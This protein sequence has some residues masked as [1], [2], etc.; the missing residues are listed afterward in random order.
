M[1]KLHILVK[2]KGDWKVAKFVT[3]KETKVVNYSEQSEPT[4]SLTLKKKKKKN[5]LLHLL[6]VS[7]AL[8]SKL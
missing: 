6:N 2:H 4:L 8:L 1:L 5:Y 7:S 3:T